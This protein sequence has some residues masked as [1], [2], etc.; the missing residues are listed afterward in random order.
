MIIMTNITRTFILHLIG[1]HPLVQNIIMDW[2]HGGR[3]WE[4]A[5]MDIVKEFYLKLEQLE[6]NIDCLPEEMR[7]KLRKETRF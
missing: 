4:E 3:T 5:M 7:V 2:R 6:Y 1:N